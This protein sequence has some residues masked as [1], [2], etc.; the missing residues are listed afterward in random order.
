MRIC[1]PC[2]SAFDDNLLLCPHCG[3]PTT[4][5]E[6]KPVVLDDMED[7][8]TRSMRP[9][10]AQRIISRLQGFVQRIG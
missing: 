4:P 1:Y 6:T 3:E 5:A 10:M 9:S 8:V 2:A 7:E